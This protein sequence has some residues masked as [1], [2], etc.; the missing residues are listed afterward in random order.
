MN[1]DTVE[2]GKFGSHF[3]SDFLAELCSLRTW[4]ILLSSDDMDELL[5]SDHMNELCNYE[6]KSSDIC[7]EL[8]SCQNQWGIDEVKGTYAGSHLISL[9]L[10]CS[11]NVLTWCQHIAQ[12]VKLSLLSERFHCVVT[13]NQL[14]TW[15]LMG[16]ACQM[17]THYSTWCTTFKITAKF[18]LFCRNNM[19]KLQSSTQI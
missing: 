12:R 2:T 9:L 5:S 7:S 15:S 16:R 19:K 18:V 17:S 1:W 4:K 8:L 6:L 14:L 13:I 10:N 11:K 3:C